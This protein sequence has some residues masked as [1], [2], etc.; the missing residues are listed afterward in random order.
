[1]LNF[2]RHCLGGSCA[3]FG[4]LIV[5][6]QS[7]GATEVSTQESNSEDLANK[8]TISQEVVL[9]DSELSLIE[10]VNTK[11]LATDKTGNSLQ[12]NSLQ[13]QVTSVSQV[14]A[15]D[16]F[17]SENQSSIIQQ[18]QNNTASNQP[19]A[20]VTSVSQLSDVQP[21][22]WAFV[23]LQSLVESTLR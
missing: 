1:M 22:D 8:I 11:A 17:S 21:T 9:I 5:L 6:S 2:L 15:T 3:V 19:M 10:A 4:F 14:A 16:T 7:V 23:A 12:Q 20:Q 13:A 18:K